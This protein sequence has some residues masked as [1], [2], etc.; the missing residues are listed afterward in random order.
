MSGGWYIPATEDIGPCPFPLSHVAPGQPCSSTIADAAGY[1]PQARAFVCV[2]AALAFVLLLE[3]LPGLVATPCAALSGGGVGVSLRA[4]QVGY[5]LAV[6]LC[7]IAV[8]LD[9]HGNAGVLDPALSWF[10]FNMGFSAIVSWMLLISLQLIALATRLERIVLRRAISRDV[11]SSLL[12]TARWSCAAVVGVSFAVTVGEGFRAVAIPLRIAWYVFLAVFMLS[13]PIAALAVSST[14]LVRLQRSLVVLTQEETLRGGLWA[15]FHAGLA[16]KAAAEDGAATPEAPSSLLLLE[17]GPSQVPPAGAGLPRDVSPLPFPP[18]SPPPPS[19]SVRAALRSHE[20]A[21]KGIR[22]ACATSLLIACI[23]TVYMV[24]LFV[25]S[26]IFLPPSVYVWPGFQGV[27]TPDIRSGFNNGM[28]GNI[29][30]SSVLAVA[31]LLLY[32]EARLAR[33]LWARC[34]GLAP[35]VSGTNNRLR[36]RNPKVRDQ[37]AAVCPA[38]LVV[39]DSGEP[40]AFTLGP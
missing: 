29:A 39:T 27:V 6:S 31:T 32:G 9:Y 3:L 22:R 28:R 25:T 11:A 33:H 37:G 10:G 26:P 40:S 1:T 2:N 13:F 35:E 8:N 24:L 30:V 21:L 34:A 18:V 36:A 4:V 16:D 38:V 14:V 17:G 5:A 23:R 19:P 12:R 7:G 15:Q 20:L